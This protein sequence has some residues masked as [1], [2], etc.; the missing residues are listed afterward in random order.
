[1]ADLTEKLVAQLEADITRF[2]KGMAQAY[3]VMDKQANAMEKRQ[4]TLKSRLEN[5]WN[6]LTSTG[7]SKF[8]SVAAI[9]EFSRAVITSTAGL[10]DQA[11][12]AGVTVEALQAYR[13][14]MKDAGGTAEEAD[15]IIKKFNVSIGA[16]KEG[17]A[18]AQDAFA[19]LGLG[20]QDLEGGTEQVI[21][22]VARALQS[23]PDA[24]VRARIETELFGRSGQELER[25]LPQVA[26]GIEAV[27][28]KLREQHRL[29]DDGIAEK[30]KDALTDLAAAWD[31]VKIASAP[32]ITSWLK[33]FADLIDGAK[34]A[35]EWIDRVFPTDRELLHGKFTHTPDM[36]FANA[37]TIALSKG[38]PAGGGGG[39]RY[40]TTD[41][42]KAAKK[43]QEEA[44]RFLKEM[45]ESANRFLRE[46]DK[47]FDTAFHDAQEKARAAVNQT[48]D[49]LAAA[50]ADR[51]VAEHATQADLLQGT[52]KYY[53]ARRTLALDEL[54]NQIGAIE[55]GKTAEYTALA[56]NG[57][58]WEQ[59]ADARANIEAAANAR[60]GAARANFQRTLAGLEEEQTHAREYQIQLLDEVRSGF[61]DMGIAGTHGFDSLKKAGAQFLDQLAEMA[62]RIYLLK[63]LIE[64]SFGPAGTKG[65]GGWLGDA[66][67]WLGLPTGGGVPAGAQVTPQIVGSNVGGFLGFASGGRPP[68]DRPSIVGESGPELF[69]PDSAGTI[70][71]RMP[72]IPRITNAA[73]TMNVQ[74]TNHVHLSGANGDETIKAY[75]R[76]GAI[77]G[78]SVAI[79]AIKQQF[80]SLMMKASRDRL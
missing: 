21:A 67:S 68:T 24:A 64:A 16:A 46:W 59:N 70:I 6:G 15:T 66:L 69:F 42:K 22:R 5:G 49:D 35:A 28:E 71:P 56:E 55:R 48:S 74:V 33:D 30:A 14:I 80:P 10:V 51:S 40:Q 11:H 73:P 18:A 2:E 78:A 75:A 20:P 1:M 72:S 36:P 58:A 29:I 19:H 62:V 8:L 3:A 7:L 45:N 54:N 65:V 13:A 60:I 23:V 31:S 27:T 53:D 79:S 41:E 77:E 61:E 17:G 57:A 50:N 32:T 26:S 37:D 47:T 38:A 4:A 63:P 34:S 12:V 39:P 52:T 76:Q 43:A 44:L 25:I 9:E